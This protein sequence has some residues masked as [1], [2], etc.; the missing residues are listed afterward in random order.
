M[1]PENLRRRYPLCASLG[2][3]G[4]KATLGQ[5]I[6]Q[7]LSTEFQLLIPKPKINRRQFL[8]LETGT[9]DFR[10]RGRWYT[11]DYAGNRRYLTPIGAVIAFPEAVAPGT[12]IGRLLEAWYTEYRSQTYRCRSFAPYPTYTTQRRVSTPVPAQVA[13]GLLTP[14]SSPTQKVTLT[15]YGQDLMPPE[16][17][18]VKPNKAGRVVLSQY[19]ISLGEI[20]MEIP[21][22]VEV[23]V[24]SEERW[25]IVSWSSHIPAE[26]GQRLFFRKL[27]VK[28]M[29]G[30]D[31][32]KGFA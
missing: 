14:P 31:I 10:N 19:K 5:Q 24:R 18:L 27:G 8:A 29:F 3:T 23:F 30:F 21:D 22:G 20:G 25:K 1:Y 2:I 9:N 11:F 28:Y 7:Q 16:S 32:E 15:F 26:P 17:I 12:T 4:P 6:E 13:F